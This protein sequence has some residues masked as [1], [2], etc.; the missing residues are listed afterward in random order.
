MKGYEQ[1]STDLIIKYSNAP[2]FKDLPHLEIYDISESRYDDECLD[3]SESHAALDAII[4]KYN[5]IIA[6]QEA[7]EAYRAERKAERGRVVGGGFG[8]GGALKGM[9]AAGAM[10]AISGAGHSLV[11]ALGNAGS[12]LEAASSKRALYNSDATKTVLCSAITCDI[13]SCFNAHIRLVNNRKTG[14]FIN[15]F[16]PDKGEALLENAK[17][18]PDKRTELLVQSFECCPWSDDLLSYMFS[19]DKKG[20]KYIWDAGLRF[21]V[22]LHKAAEESFAAEY[23]VDAQN[24]EEKAQIVKA[25]I[26]AQ[27]NELGIKSS[28]TINRI[29]K[30]GVSRILASYDFAKEAQRQ[31]LFSKVEQYDADNKN[32]AFVIHKKGVWE[33]AKKYNVHFSADEIEAILQKAYPETSRNSETH[34]QI[35]KKKIKTIMAAL[36]VEDSSTLNSLETDCIKRLCPD[37]HTANETTCNEMLE[38]IQAYDALEKNKA[39][40]LNGIQQRIEAIWAAEDGEIFD[41]LYLKT[42]I[43]KADEVNSAIEFV[44]SKGRTASSQKYLTALNH[45]NSKNI[46]K[47]VRFKKPISTVSLVLGIL[48]IVTGIFIGFVLL[49]GFVPT[50][51][52]LFLGLFLL[53]LRSDW[54]KMWK[55]LTLSESLIHPTLLQA[56]PDKKKKKCASATKSTPKDEVK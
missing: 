1:K 44:K 35:A 3:F 17:K 29:E 56:I 43:Q 11:N 51:I 47:A 8:V 6:Q 21:H 41:N 53:F 2:L 55:I 25:D 16:D 37:Y 48:L 27:M 34:A 30:D 54:K 10:N 32:K 36:G 45:C 15:C 31:E 49:A 5:D 20:R 26:L 4:D 38:K 42:N 12:A 19:L 18:V 14:Y 33:L 9:A 52:A 39:P 46:Q 50:F 7:E 22:D 28:N 13:V 23:T 24:S 40:F